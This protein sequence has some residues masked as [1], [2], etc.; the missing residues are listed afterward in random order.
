MGSLRIIFKILTN[1]Q[2]FQIPIN[3]DDHPLPLNQER[4]LWDPFQELSEDHQDPR[5]SFPAEMRRIKDRSGQER[6][7]VVRSGLK[8]FKERIGAENSQGCSTPLRS[9]AVISNPQEQEALLCSITCST[10]KLI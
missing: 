10:K 8:L 2:E 6:I 4:I 7:R 9:R 3:P 1:L 5:G